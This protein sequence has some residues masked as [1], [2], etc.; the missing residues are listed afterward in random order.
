MKKLAI[1]IKDG[2]AVLAAGGDFEA[3]YIR[4][5]FDETDFAGET[6]QGKPASPLSLFD[7]GQKR[8][9]ELCRNAE[10]ITLSAPMRFSLIKMVSV[11]AAAVELYGQEF[12]QWEARQQLP[13]EIGEFVAGFN[14]LGIDQ[15]QK[16]INYLFYAVPRDFIEVLLGFVTF[17]QNRKPALE[18]E[19]M[20][21]YKI[22]NLATSGSGF[23][24]AVSLE[25]DGASVIIVKNGNFVAGRFIGGDGLELADE[26]M[27]YVYG[28][29]PEAT[30]PGLLVCGDTTYLDLLGKI[31]WARLISLPDSTAESSGEV[32]DQP[33]FAVVAG[34]NLI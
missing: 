26:I 20:G 27:Y 3:E 31:S 4:I 30:T 28:F 16:R 33:A 29:A 8:V 21:L 17:D 15:R 22:L 11:D 32:A 5:D 6:D 24:A 1:D 9:L 25:H 18:S 23:N 13:D 19:A 7:I 34:L 14:K 2:Y 12:L 10:R